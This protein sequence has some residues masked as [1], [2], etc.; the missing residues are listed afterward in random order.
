[1]LSLQKK[2]HDEKTQGNEKERLKSQI[3]NVDYELD[4]EVYKLYGITDEEKKVIE[5]EEK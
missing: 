5:R 2:Y 1:M 4:S 3:D